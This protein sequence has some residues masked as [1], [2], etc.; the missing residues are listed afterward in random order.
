MRR[1]SFLLS[2]F[3]VTPLAAASTAGRSVDIVS[4]DGFDLRGTFYAAKAPGPGILLL[5]QCNG[6]RTGYVALA[7]ML[8]EAG[9]HTLSFDFR[10]FGESRAGGTVDFRSDRELWSEFSGDV[11]AAYEFLLQQPNVE[12]A[13]IGLLGASC[14]GSQAALLSLRRPEIRAIVLLS[15]SLPRIERE[16]VIAF[17]TTSAIPILCIA[18][19]GDQRTAQVTRDVFGKSKNQG[20]RLI[21][22]KGT[23]HGAPLFRLDGSLEE[24]IVAWV[25]QALAGG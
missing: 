10:G 16:D 3:L 1:L 15:S 14:G 19:E 18:S 12:K 5:H 23:A 4:H 7:P 8:A 2:L 20:S 13:S 24:T 17:E 11:D 21:L 22:Y 9:F 25:L 6:D